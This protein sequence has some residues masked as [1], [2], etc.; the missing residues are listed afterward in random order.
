MET[1]AILSHDEVVRLATTPDQNGWLI[2]RS[3]IF[4]PEIDQ[5]E[6]WRDW[7]SRSNRALTEDQRT[8]YALSSTIH[9][10]HRSG[11]IVG[12]FEEDISCWNEILK[13]LD[14]LA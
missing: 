3:L 1:R 5:A 10:A 11:G 2:G 4:R 8:V 14:R 6:G 13:L 7:E 9:Y 12:W